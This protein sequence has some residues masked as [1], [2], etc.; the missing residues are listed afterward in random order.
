MIKIV[1]GCHVMIELGGRAMP[2]T[3]YFVGSQDRYWLA[4]DADQILILS[5]HQ[6]HL[7]Q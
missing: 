7:F 3:K 1:N 2:L 5:V 6:R 4:K